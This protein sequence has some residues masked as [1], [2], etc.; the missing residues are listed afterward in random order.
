MDVLVSSCGKSP[1][2]RLRQRKIL[3]SPCPHTMPWRAYFDDG[4]VDHAGMAVR[5]CARSSFQIS[6][7]RRLI[8]VLGAFSIHKGHDS[9]RTPDQNSSMIHGTSQ[10]QGRA[11]PKC[12][13]FFHTAADFCA[14]EYISA[15]QSLPSALFLVDMMLVQRLSR[16]I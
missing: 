10:N 16:H 11:N 5:G 6:Y 15:R 1:R 14:P 7:G 12:C 13:H 2:L 3:L 4:F 9:Q 8:G